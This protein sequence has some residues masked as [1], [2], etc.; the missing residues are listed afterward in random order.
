MKEGD[1]EDGWKYSRG[2]MKE[3]INM[4]W[5]HKKNGGRVPT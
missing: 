3:T 1:Y 4:V 2:L 5:P